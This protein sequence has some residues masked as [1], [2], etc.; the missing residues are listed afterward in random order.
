VLPEP[1]N[2]IIER[3]QRKAHAARDLTL[4]QR[5]FAREYAKTRNAKQSAITAGYS[6]HTA[7]QIRYKLTKHPRVAELVRHEREWVTT[8]KGKKCTVSAKI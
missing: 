3:I 1:L 4:K 2:G 5:T 7:E 6:A 8:E